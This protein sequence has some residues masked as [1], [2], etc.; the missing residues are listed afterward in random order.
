MR[1]EAEARQRL[2]ASPGTCVQ[3]LLVPGWSVCHS[4]RCY[5]DDGSAWKGEKASFME[6]EELASLGAEIST[7]CSDLF[8][9]AKFSG[10]GI[11]FRSGS[12]NPFSKCHGWS[13][14]KVA[15]GATDLKILKCFLGSSAVSITLFSFRK[16]M[17]FGGA[18][19]F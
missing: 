17:L 9:D 6:R 2:L 14:L 10:D 13:P 16:P 3:A 12:R 11:V 19:V 15:V 5:T 8:L 18:F 7:L 4:Q 1:E